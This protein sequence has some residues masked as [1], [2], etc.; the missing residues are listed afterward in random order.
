MLLFIE[1]AFLQ[2]NLGEA[3]LHHTKSGIFQAKFDD[4]SASADRGVH[5]FQKQALFD[6]TAEPL[7]TSEETDTSVFSSDFQLLPKAD[8]SLND[9]PHDELTDFPKQPNR[10]SDNYG[11]VEHPSSEQYQV[12]SA[13]A[14]NLEAVKVSLIDARAAGHETLPTFASFE[15]NKPSIQD[16]TVNVDSAEPQ[17]NVLLIDTKTSPARALNLLDTPVRLSFGYPESSPAFH[18]FKTA[19]KSQS[20]ASEVGTLGSRAQSNTEENNKVTNHLSRSEMTL[21]APDGVKGMSEKW[22]MLSTHRLSDA[23]SH[24]TNTASLPQ[25]LDRPEGM[26]DTPVGKESVGQ[27]KELIQHTSVKK[28]FDTSSSR[29][30]DDKAKMVAA[31]A[32]PKQDAMPERPTNFSTALFYESQPTDELLLNLREPSSHG[33]RAESLSSVGLKATEPRSEAVASNAIMRQITQVMSNKLSDGFFEVRLQPEELGR[34]RLAMSISDSGLA[35][36]ITTERPDTLE[37]IRRHIDLLEDDFRRQGFNEI[38]VS[39]DDERNLN[40]EAPFFS[41]EPLEPEDEDLEN[42]LSIEIVS[43]SSGKISVQDQIDIRI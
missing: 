21:E 13:A 30:S 7:E 8:T 10:R 15:P 3:R 11:D 40:K 17:V 19:Q 20:V 39:L 42:A 14:Y 9:K 36:H 32:Y 43:R 33:G 12:I 22:T 1:S 26:K 28:S 5:R 29:T 16:K 35:V 2:P 41:F 4:A 31:H 25:V 27:R 6:L 37:L 24:S 34:V 38:D 18:E 23:R